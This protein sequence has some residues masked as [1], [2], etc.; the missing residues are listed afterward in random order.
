MTHRNVCAVRGAIT[1]DSN[2]SIAIASAT[3]ELLEGII[4]QNGLLPEDIISAFFTLTPDLDASFPASAA[5]ELPGWNLIPMLCANEVAVRNE[6]PMCIRVMIH[7]YS[8]R[9][10]DQIKHVYLRGA[11][12]LRPDL[13]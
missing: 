1:V 10:R 2:N 8:P 3:L 7:C 5:R 13:N 4:Q 9:A 11:K 6:L 12:V